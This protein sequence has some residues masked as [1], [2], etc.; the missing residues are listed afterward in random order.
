MNQL[1]QQLLVL[2]LLFT[3]IAG[4]VIAHGWM[5]LVAL[6]PLFAFYVVVERILQAYGVTP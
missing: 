6:F 4:I 5:K 1:A 3:W 2:V